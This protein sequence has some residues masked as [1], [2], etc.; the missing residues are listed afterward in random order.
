M[1]LDA[2][3]EP[4]ELLSL[5]FGAPEMTERPWHVDWAA[6]GLDPDGVAALVIR[7]LPP[8][9]DFHTSGSTGPR[10]CWRRVREKVWQEATMLAGFLA[11]E[12]PEALVSFVPPMHL[13]GALTSVLVPGRLGVPAWYRPTIFGAMPVPDCRRIAV[14]ASPWVFTLLLEQMEWVRRFDSVTVLYGSAMLPATAGEFLERAGAERASIVEVLGSTE[15]GGIARRQWRS[16][17]PP[18]WTLFPDVS[19]AGPPADA[20]SDEVSLVVSGPRLAFP[21]GGEPPA[22]CATDDFVQ[23]LDDRTFRFSGRR[24]RLV[25]VNGRR[26]NLDEAE[27]ALRAVLD[28]AD[29]AVVPVADRMIGEHVDLL[30]VLKPGTTLAD[31]DLAAGYARLGVRPRHVRVVPRIDRS[32]LGKLRHVQPSPSTDAEVV[33]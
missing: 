16:G 2:K 3:L 25:K 22:S 7:S 9:I 17:D 14:V 13:Y 4:E 30:L 11:P 27:Y 23:P 28:S 15:A 32:E 26:I 19:F 5:D 18:P 29:L 8:V 6:S 20:G 24:T 33:K 31:L 10:H 1:L 21:P 12:R